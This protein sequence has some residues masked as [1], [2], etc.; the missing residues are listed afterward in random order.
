MQFKNNGV[1]DSHVNKHT[2]YGW[3]K[4][5]VLAWFGDRGVCLRE[6]D[7]IKWYWQDGVLFY[8]LSQLVNGWFGANPTESGYVEYT[9]THRKDRSS[10]WIYEPESIIP[11]EESPFADVQNES[12]QWRKI[13]KF[14]G[15]EDRS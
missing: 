6:K 10:I 3:S 12:L 15:F 2:K 11:I 8:I 4:P 14:H 1:Y 13:V 9:T 5:Q 7:L